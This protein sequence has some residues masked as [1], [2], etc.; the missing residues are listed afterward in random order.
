MRKYMV[1]AALGLLAACLIVVVGLAL[2]NEGAIVKR[3][4]DGD[5][6]ELASGEKVRYIG[7][8]APEVV[9]PSKPVEYYGREAFHYNRGLVEGKEVRLDFD[10][11]RKDKYDR[12]MAYVYLADGTFVNAELI[13]LGY[14]KASRYPSN[15]KHEEEFLELEKKAESDWRGLW[16]KPNPPPCTGSDNVVYITKRGSKYHIAGCRYLK[17]CIIPIE[18][19]LAERCDYG[20]CS[21][22]NP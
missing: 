6:I 11:E 16:G 21:R 20:P 8:D 15:I 4:I 7:T 9:H 14:A 17:K 19:D 5:T 1:K 12:L 3:V 10:V 22:C 13:R 2:E 18:R